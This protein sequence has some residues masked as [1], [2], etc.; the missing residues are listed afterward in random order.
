MDLFRALKGFF[1]ALL[2]MKSFISEIHDPIVE[3]DILDFA[4]KINSFHNGKYDEEKFKSLRLVRGVYGQRQKGVQMVRIKIPMGRLT[5]NQLRTIATISDTYS[6][7][8]LHA[9]TR[10][11]IQIHYVSLDDT[12]ELWAR[13]EKEDITLREACGN[14]VRNITAAD[15]AGV[16]PEEPFDVTP[17]AHA[18]Y[19]Y[20]LRNPIC[21]Q[22]GR[23]FKIA[24]SSSETDSA[25]TLIHD[26][27]LIPKIR[28]GQRGFKVMIGGG[29]GAVPRLAEVACEFLPEDELLPF[30]EAVLRVFD[31]HGERKRRMKARMK[32]LIADIGLEAFLQLVEA[33]RKVLPQQEIKVDRNVYVTDPPAQRNHEEERVTDEKAFSLWKQTNVFQQK[34]AGWYGIY[35]RVPLG[36]ISTETARALANLVDDYAGNDIRVTINQGFMLRFVAE[37]ALEAV[38]NRLSKLGL[39]LPGFDSVV[40]ITACPGTDTCNLG[41]SSSTGI[42]RKLE[43]FITKEF[44]H[45][46]TNRDIKIKISGC[47]N[48]CGQHGIATIGFHGSSLKVGDAVLP[49]LQVVLGGLVAEDGKGQAAEKVIKIPSKRGLEAV[50]ILLED[51]DQHKES[52]ERFPAYF[53]RQGKMYFYQLL[54]PLTDVSNPDPDMFIDWGREEAFK[55]ETEVGEC[56]GVMIDLVSVLLDETQEELENGAWSLQNNKDADAAYFAYKGYVDTAKAMLLTKDITTNNHISILE[57]FEEHFPEYKAAAGNSLKE[58]VLRIREEKS[59]HEFAKTYLEDAVRF[60]KQMKASRKVGAD[61]KISTHA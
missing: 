19:R 31:R 6:N 35:L 42:A 12:P 52:E 17:Y 40:D 4:G 36:N 8:M 32:F 15:K 23:K 34:Q 48:S 20:F 2:I 10:Q 18:M 22:M 45:L 43:E 50:R 57:L 9:T 21:Q 28:D 14:T 61:N 46:L 60:F 1:Y 41:I 33:E 13:L 26:I 37:D 30:G 5:T 47:P 38:Y 56:A 16:D 49:A 29:L 59:T 51:F 58:E 27:G 11:D 24:F 39:A 53:N 44:P 54:K 7:G 3:Q 55:V 25:F